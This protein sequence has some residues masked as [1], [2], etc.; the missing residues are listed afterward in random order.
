MQA[1]E[2]LISKIKEG[3]TKSGFPLEMKIGAILDNSNWAY[4][5]GSLYKDF[6]TEKIREIDLSAEKT[7]NGISIHLEIACKKSTEKQLVLYAPKF[8]SKDF[9]YDSYFKALPAIF[10]GQEKQKKI[11]SKK[12]Y[13]AF[14]NLDIFSPNI[15]ISKKLIVTKGNI[16]TEDNIKFLSDFNGLVKHSVITGSDGY[17][18]TGYR[19]IYLYIMVFDGLI[20]SLTPSS[21]EDFDL[22]SCEYGNLIYEPNLKFSS[23]ETE[24]LRNDLIETSRQLKSNRVIVEIMTP[25]YFQEYIKTVEKTFTNLDKKLLKNWGE[26]WPN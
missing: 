6:E 1:P 3:I 5:I 9:F 23:S 26:D 20:F 8:Q 4:S 16:N 21:E 24:S 12:I 14:K 25:E 7:I 15:P 19:I 22:V 13:S 18:E 11:S 17:I 10:W 2:N